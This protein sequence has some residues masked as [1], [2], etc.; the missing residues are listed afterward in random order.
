M[1]STCSKSGLLF[2]T[3]ILDMGADPNS[4]LAKN[5]LQDGLA[6]V[7]IEM[8]DISEHFASAHEKLFQMGALAPTVE[9]LKDFIK[10]HLTANDE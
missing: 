4:G 2:G 5:D 3:N 7:R 8:G 9:I 6:N 10:D 1:Q